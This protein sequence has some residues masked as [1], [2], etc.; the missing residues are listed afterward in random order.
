MAGGT[1]FMLSAN[2][3]QSDADD[4]CNSGKFGGRCDPAQ[5]NEIAALDSDASSARTLSNVGFIVGGVGVAAGVTLL[6]LSGKPSKAARLQPTIE[7]WVG[8]GS[9]GV[10]GSF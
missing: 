2:G 1:I 9:A 10:F 8:L 7:P 6:L 4:L 3:K 5:R